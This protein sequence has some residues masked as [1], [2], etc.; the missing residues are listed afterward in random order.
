MHPNLRGALFMVLSMCAFAV[1]DALLKHAFAGIPPGLAFTLF[2]LT[3]LF[4]CIA[5]SKRAGDAVFPQSFLSKPLMIRSAIELVGRLFFTLSLAFVSLSMTTVILQ[6]APLVVALGAQVLFG[7]RI[8]PRRWIAMG[9]GFAGVL[10]ILRPA[11]GMFDPLVILPILGMLGFAGRD[12][13]TRASPPHISSRQLGTLG[14]SVTTITGLIMWA[15]DPRLP[16]AATTG[17]WGAIIAAGIVGTIAYNTLT[18]A[19]RS[20]E[21]SVVAPFRYSRLIVALLIAFFIFHERPD[22]TTLIGGA[23]I[24]ISGIYTLLRSQKPKQHA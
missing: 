24:V 2:S 6:A 5:L 20:G 1:E 17:Q 14:F 10:M 19:M 16:Q 8:G 22:I 18:L 21:I 3:A 7:E 9:V 4:I 15:F 23:L 12:L 11:P 13:A